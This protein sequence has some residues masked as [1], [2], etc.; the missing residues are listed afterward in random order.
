MGLLLTLPGG[1]SAPYPGDVQAGRGPC[2]LLEK[3]YHRPETSLPPT[4]AWSLRQSASAQPCCFACWVYSSAR[5]VS[6]R[7]K[8]TSR[9]PLASGGVGGFTA[10]LTFM[11]HS[12]AGQ[13]PRRR[14]SG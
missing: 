5:S 3:V 9:T 13:G 14:R 11:A 2:P 6:P 10:L 7:G 8:N 4:R 12:P 1:A